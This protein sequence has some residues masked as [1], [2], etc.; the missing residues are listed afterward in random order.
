MYSIGRLIWKSLTFFGEGNHS[1]S[2]I[3]GIR[4]FIRLTVWHFAMVA[5]A[6]GVIH[7]HR[8]LNQ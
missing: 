3:N 2:F 4:S 8:I 5:V 6:S 1:M 7:V